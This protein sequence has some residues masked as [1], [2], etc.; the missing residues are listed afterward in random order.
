MT[1]PYDSIL[2]R[3]V[4]RVL[5]TTRTFYPTEFDV[6]EGD[7]RLSGSIVEVDET[8]GRATAIRR[9]CVRE[10]EIDAGR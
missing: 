10:D 2:G 9:V 1:G 4:D 5:E 7:A 6:A 3:R 8:T